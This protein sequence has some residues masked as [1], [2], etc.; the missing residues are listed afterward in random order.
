MS[1]KYIYIKSYGCQM[2]VYD[3]NRIKDLFS[4]K[5]YKIT[6]DISKADLTVLNTCHIREKAVEKVYSDI[7]RVKKIKDKKQ[8][9]KLVVAGC[10]AQAEGL[11]IKK[12]SPSVDYVVGPQSYH[13]LPDMI[14]KVD[15]IE[16]SEFLQNEK[17]KNLIFNSSNLSSEFLSIQEGC[18][19]FCSFCVVP[20]TRGPEF[21]RP[22]DDIVEETKKYVSNGIKEIILLGQNVNAYHG[23]ASDGKSKDLAYLINK[24]S[25]IEEI[26]RIRYMTSHPIDMKDS[27]INAHADNSKLMPFLHLPIQSGSDKILKKMNRKHSSDEYLSLVKKIKKLLPDCGISHDMICGFPDETENDHLDTISLMNKVKYDFGFMFKYSERPGTLAARK[28]DDNVPEE[29][30]QRRLSE[31]IDLQLKHCFENLSNY[32][33]KYSNV[34]I[35]KESKKSKEYWCGR[36]P[37]NIMVVFPKDD[38]KIGDYAKVKILSNTSTTLIGKG[39]K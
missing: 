19:K 1:D 8:N 22:V 9:M 31:I 2:N 25:E 36:N 6:K 23:V 11:E 15:E 16:N 30:K 34:L 27:L 33:N 7:G 24:I 26:K 17:F 20:Y 29:V 35:E 10:V 4:N 12:R 38:F 28:F 39:F 14:D 3:S 13:K 5:G 18:D 32:I 37:Q 21:S